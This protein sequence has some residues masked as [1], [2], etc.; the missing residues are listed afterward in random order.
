MANIDELLYEVNNELN[1]E[2]CVKEYLRLKKIIS[3]D[4]DIARLDKE[5]RLHQR[6]MCEHQNNDDLY[7]KEKAFYEK[8]LKELESNP[9]YVNF[10]EVKKEVSTL[11]LDVRDYLN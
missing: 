9:I 7:F 5:V 1:E 10:M 3:N 2:E 8:T 6:K 11:L 4:E